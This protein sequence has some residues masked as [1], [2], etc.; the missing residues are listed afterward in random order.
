MDYLQDAPALVTELS[1]FNQWCHFLGFSIHVILIVSLAVAAVLGCHVLYTRVNRTL[2][3][4]DRIESKI[5]DW[6]EE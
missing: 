3:Q 4:I 1:L 5:D 6:T 2:A